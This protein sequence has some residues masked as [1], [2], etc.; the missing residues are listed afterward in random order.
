MGDGTRSEDLGDFLRT[1]RAEL[2]PDAAGIVSYGARRVAGLRREEL[3]LLA[4]V[5][6][7]YYTRLEQGQSTGA[8]ESVI[9]SLARALSLNDDERAHLHDLARP[10]KNKRRHAP[11]P[12]RVR[13]GILRLLSAMTEI[14]AVVM[15]RRN[16]VLAWN[17]LGHLLLA[18]H[19]DPD[20]P[21]RPSDRPN[22]T[23]MLFLDAHTRDLYRNWREEATKAV[24][25][26]RFTAAQHKGDPELTQLIGELTLN[27]P[28]F[29]AL[30]AKHPVQR[31]VSGTK[32]FHHPEVGDFDLD[33]QVLHLPDGD[34][35][36]L[37]THT[38]E[39]DSA[40]SA[41]VTLLR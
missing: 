14:P 22:L 2:T 29:A 38:A 35:Q 19:L 1:R 32:R 9:D 7:T 8:S 40:A 12:E 4:G 23:R 11:R 20:A 34:G 33:F 24:A 25:S 3:A 36:R 37:L 16:D 6:S 27:S 28:D 30:W 21:T 39:P 15:G 5:S 26:L 10:A 17:E 31:C 41:A 13:A 18:G